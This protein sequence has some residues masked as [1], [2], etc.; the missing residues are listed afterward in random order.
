VPPSGSEFSIDLPPETY[1]RVRFAGDLLDLSDVEVVDRAVTMLIA[2]EKRPPIDPWLPLAV[3][4]DYS[5]TRVEGLLIP[6]NG[7]LKVTSDP[8]PDRVFGSPSAAARAVVEKL[9]PQRAQA[10]GNGWRVWR[11][12]ETAERIEVLRIRPRDE[13]RGRGGPSRRSTDGRPE[14]TT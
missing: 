13:R 6:R 1:D 5:G 11:I 7:R 3:Y 14:R 8:L 2:W 4:F 9:N 12:T 10:Q